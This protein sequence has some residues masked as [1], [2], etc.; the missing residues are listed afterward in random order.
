VFASGNDFSKYGLPLAAVIAGAFSV[1]YSLRFIAQV[2][3]G[4]PPRNLPRAPHEP[5]LRMLIP[6]A[7]LVLTCLVVGV[8]PNFTL[9]P[10]LQIA[11]QSIL[12][13]ANTPSYDLRI[14]HGF[15]LPL[16]MSFLALV[17]GVL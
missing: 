3:F 12:G 6:S 5:P 1:A 8:L 17:G 10:I 14:W 4:P 7:V 13:G 2:F 15:N 16:A 9:G 11:A